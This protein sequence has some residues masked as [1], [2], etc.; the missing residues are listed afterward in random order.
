MGKIKVDN[1]RNMKLSEDIR[2]DQEHASKKIEDLLGYL[3]ESFDDIKTGLQ[4]NKND[5]TKIHKEVSMIKEEVNR[6]VSKIMQGK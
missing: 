1:T 6:K 4:E 3:K 5:I 2:K